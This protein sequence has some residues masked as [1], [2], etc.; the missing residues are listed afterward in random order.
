VIAYR[1]D[2]SVA[3]NY[4]G[5]VTLSVDDGTAPP[6]TNPGRITLATYTF[7]TGDDG[8]AIFGPF[9]VNFV[10]GQY[11]YRCVYAD[12]NVCGIHGEMDL[13]IWFFVL[14]TVEHEVGESLTCGG[15]VQPGQNFV[16]LPFPAPVS[17]YCGMSVAVMSAKPAFTYSE[18]QHRGPWFPYH[19]RGPGCTNY[20]DDPYWNTTGIPRAVSFEGQVR[21]CDPSDTPC[22]GSGIDLGPGTFAI[23]GNYM[24]AYWR[25]DT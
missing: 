20:P 5:T 10:Y 6:D 16:A 13:A 14:S 3:S 7:T 9:Q 2:G 23:L 11:A 8:A 12:D 21:D 25:W 1:A 4:T 24:H 18:I 17:T 15:T 22:N 19:G